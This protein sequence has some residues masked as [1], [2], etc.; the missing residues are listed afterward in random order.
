MF[1]ML[2]AFPGAKF[3][4]RASSMANKILRQLQGV[5]D[6]G[7]RHG[8]TVCDRELERIEITDARSRML[9]RQI[10]GL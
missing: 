1:D 9:V 7:Q 8:L 10:S 3:T 4:H 6:G 5:H 2:A